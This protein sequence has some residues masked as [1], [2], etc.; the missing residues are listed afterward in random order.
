MKGRTY[1]TKTNDRNRTCVHN[2][3]RVSSATELHSLKVFDS[4]STS[5]LRDRLPNCVRYLDWLGFVSRELS[6]FS[7]AYACT[8][9][10]YCGAVPFPHARE[11]T[12]FN[13]LFGFTVAKVCV[14]KLLAFH[15]HLFLFHIEHG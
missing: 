4:H 12:I 2:P 7:F 13:S 5:P 1:C 8:R 11:L 15:R 10:L 6:S 9:I 3:C 14:L